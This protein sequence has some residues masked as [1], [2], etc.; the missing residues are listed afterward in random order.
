MP[1]PLHPLMDCRTRMEWAEGD[2]KTLRDD[3]ETFGKSGAYMILIQEHSDRW[4]AHFIK[5]I[6]ADAEAKQFGQFARSFGTFLDHIRAALNYLT[7]QLA[8]LALRQDPALQ[9]K[10]NPDSVEFPIFDDPDV[11]RKKN[12]V[13]QLPE[14]YRRLL[15][16]VQPYKT[17]NDGLWLL[18]ELAREYRHRVLH[19]IFAW[20]VA[21]GYGVTVNGQEVTDLTITCD[22]QETLKHEDELFSWV[23]P[24]G[25]DRDSDVDPYAPVPI[26]LSHPLCR[27]THCGATVQDIRVAAWEVIKHVTREVPNWT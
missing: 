23:M 2:A 20:S 14:Q 17:G 15:E 9:G 1:E 12:R 8:L 5:F 16:D 19:P 4:T 25:T 27:G 7:Y 3:I 13:K 21:E 6:E 22:P 11:F 24:G 18:H 26:G 10:L